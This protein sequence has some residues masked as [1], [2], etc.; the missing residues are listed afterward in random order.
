MYSFEFSLVES[1]ARS[2]SSSFVREK[3]RTTVVCSSEGNVA[4]RLFSA[5]PYT[6]RKMSSLR[7]QGLNFS[8]NLVRVDAVDRLGA[9]QGKPP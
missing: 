3:R 5:I 6:G 1:T 7:P 9:V 4:A 2:C 8:R